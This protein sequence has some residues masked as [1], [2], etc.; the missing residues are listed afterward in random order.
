MLFFAL[1]RW[2]FH[3]CSWSK[4][5]QSL[6]LCVVQGYRLKKA[7]ISCLMISDKEWWQLQQQIFD[8]CFLS[9]IKTCWEAAPCCHKES[10]QCPPSSRRQSVIQRRLCRPQFCDYASP[11]P[12]G[13]SIS[14]LKSEDRKLVMRSWVASM[15]IMNIM[16]FINFALW[17][18]L[19]SCIYV[20]VF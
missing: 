5:W 20:Q 10:L 1:V 4:N 2:I 15:G 3:L 13:A 7:P 6:T 12:S 8:C 17:A 14:S 9:T 16:N 18:Q 19:S 11:T